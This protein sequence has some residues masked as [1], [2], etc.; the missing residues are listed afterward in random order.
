MLIYL[1]NKGEWL[2][3]YKLIFQPYVA[4]NLLKLGNPIYDVKEDKQ[5]KGHTVFVFEKTEKF[6]SDLSSILKK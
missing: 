4:R 2:I 3:E 5:S 6:I 1:K